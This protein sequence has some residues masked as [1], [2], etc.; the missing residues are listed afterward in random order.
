MV[1]AAAADQVSMIITCDNGIAAFDAVRKA[2]NMGC[3]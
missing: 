3:G 2:K 1:D